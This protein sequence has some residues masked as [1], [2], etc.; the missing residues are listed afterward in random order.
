MTGLTTFLL[1]R[2]AEDEAVARAVRDNL[3][4]IHWQAEP[5]GDGW[6]ISDAQDPSNCVTCDDEGGNELTQVTATHIAHYDPARVF[7]ECD[8]KREIVDR[9]CDAALLVDLHPDA[10]ALAKVMVAHLAA[11]YSDHP[12]YRDEWRP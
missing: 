11:V 5:D 8:A 4:P 10:W 2:I 1:A 6:A 3:Y 12:D 7:A 9:L